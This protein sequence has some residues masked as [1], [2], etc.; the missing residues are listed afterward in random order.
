MELDKIALLIL[1][2]FFS[3]LWF[4]IKWAKNYKQPALL[5][6]DL[7]LIP[8]QKSP[9]FKKKFSNFPK[10]CLLLSLVGFL[11]AFL[12]PHD[13]AL[14]SHTD[15]NNLPKEGIAIYLLADESGSMQEIINAQMQD[16][17][18][19][20]TSK[21]DFLKQVTIPFIEQRKNDLIGLISF[22]R[23]ADIKAPLTLDHEAIVKEIALL[24]PTTLESNAGTAIGYAVFKTVNLI[25]ATKHFANDMI[26]SG[27]PAYE[28]K[29]SIIV[30]V[31]DGVQNVNSEDVND[32]Y[33]SMDIKEAADF[34]KENEVRLYIINV[35]PSILTNKFTAERNLMN[36][37]TELTGGHFYVV[38]SS[39]SLSDIYEE[40]NKIEKNEINTPPTKDNLPTQY[41]RI[42]FYPYFIAA[43]LCFMLLYLISETT[44][45]KRVP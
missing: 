42:S 7:N 33:R 23:T 13:F 9:S 21:I 34:A 3:F 41:R 25:I 28:I 18:F 30:L 15:Q 10:Y 32:K 22:A 16:G 43:A 5:F 35:D 24:N 40:I 8:H 38:D 19:E 14:K 6:P 26:K 45:F 17:R 20:K 4:F 44:F 36:R 27:K 29:N 37:V 31:T 12:D 11:I 1:I 39:N 2:C